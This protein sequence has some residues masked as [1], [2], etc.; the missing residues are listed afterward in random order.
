MQV[1]TLIK[2]KHITTESLG[3]IVG[4][5]KPLSFGD[6]GPVYKIQWIDAHPFVEHLKYLQSDSME[7][8]S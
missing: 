3:I 5:E 4:I 1:G 6:G 7:K 8:V 2:Y